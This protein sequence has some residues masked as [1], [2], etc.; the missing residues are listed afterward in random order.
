MAVGFHIGRRIIL[1]LE[2]IDHLRSA[3]HAEA[4]FDGYLPVMHLSLFDVAARFDYLKPAQF[5]E[6][7]VGTSNGLVHGVL[8]GGGGSAGEFDEF[9]DGVFHFGVFRL[10][11][12]QRDGSVAAQGF[13]IRT[14]LVRFVHDALRLG[15]IDSVQLG[16]QL[17]RH[18]QE[19]E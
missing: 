12:H 9:I 14:G 2:A 15:M 7:F 13:G 16:M 8:D 10:V 17:H 18:W 3:F 11:H 19:P 5:L 1:L 4:H 6:G